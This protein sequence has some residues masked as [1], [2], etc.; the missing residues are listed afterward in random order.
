M[1]YSLFK[2]DNFRNFSSFSI[3]SLERVNLIT[4]RNNAGKTALLEALYLHIGCMN[5]NLANKLNVF[6]NLGVAPTAEGAVW[7]FMFRNLDT[8]KVI[9]LYGKFAD[10]T[11]SRLLISM[12][13]KQELQNDLNTPDTI[14]PTGPTG[15]TYLSEKALQYD[16]SHDRSKT[17]VTMEITSKGFRINPAGLRNPFDG[18]F[19]TSRN[20]PDL[21]ELSDLLGKLKVNRQDSSV[22]DALKIIEPNLRELTIV[23]YGQIP[24]VHADLGG[25]KLVPLQFA[26]EGMMRIA[27]I[28]TNMCSHPKGVGLVDDIDTGIHY[29]VLP[30]VWT[31]IS[32]LARTLDIQLFTTTHSLECIKCAREVFMDTRPFDLSVFRLQQT[33]ETITAIH[34]SKEELEAAID[35]GLEIR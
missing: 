35:T 3:N 14:G 6:R 27:Q 29:S 12:V 31:T 11:S 15:T 4:G 30:K 24:I 13:N 2:I 10:N 22:L 26:G 32:S 25:R 7:S 18:F 8:Q 19:I 16:Y 9:D 34:Y 23:P 17:R 20:N 33:E 21:T 1:N 28:V 5:P